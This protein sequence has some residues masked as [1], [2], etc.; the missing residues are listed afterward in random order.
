MPLGTG[1]D[2]S[3]SFGWGKRYASSMT[4]NRFLERVR[5]ASPVML[6]RWDIRIWADEEMT[7]SEQAWVPACLEPLEGL[8][9]GGDGDIIDSSEGKGDEGC[10]SASP[11]SGHASALNISHDSGGS[12]VSGESGDDDA[13]RAATKGTELS[14]IDIVI[15]H[16]EAV[17]TGLEDL[18]RTQ[19]QVIPTV[20]PVGTGLRGVFSNYWSVGVD[21][22]VAFDFHRERKLR[23]KRFSGPFKNQ[24]IYGCKGL[25]RACTGGPEL[26]QC[27]DIELEG[28]DDEGHDSI[29]GMRRRLAIPAGLRGIVF[30]NLQSYAGGH[31]IYRHKSNNLKVQLAPGA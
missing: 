4:S 7:A 1:N 15:L 3:R 14:D 28:G 27:V 5:A 6:D 12:A 17:E 8:V 16:S 21:A 22:A 20:S 9:E 13:T 25:K 23:P 19:S 24:F 31:T 29:S 2:L 10:T 26:R 18:T 30:L 11:A